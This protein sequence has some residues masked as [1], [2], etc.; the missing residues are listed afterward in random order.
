MAVEIEQGGLKWSAELDYE[1]FAKAGQEMEK[2]LQ[3]VADAFTKTGVNGEKAIEQLESSI[4][5]LEKQQQ[6]LSQALNHSHDPQLTDEYQK[7][8]DEINTKL[9]TQYALLD[10]LKIANEKIAS[11]DT[12]T[13]GDNGETK[14]V[15]KAISAYAE[16]RHLKSE[17]ATQPLSK[18]QFESVL[19]E[20]TEL[21]HRL[22][23]VNQELELSASN[24]AGLE[25][26][27]VGARGV[28]G[29]FE[30]AAGGIALFSDKNEELEKVLKVVIG[31]QAVLNAMEEVGNAVYKNGAL[32]VYLL[33]QF[34]KA[35]AVA[36]TEQAEATG[37]ATGAQEVQNKV[38]EEGIVAQKGLNASMLANPAAIL[39]ASLTA[40]VAI[41]AVVVE[42]LEEA[43]NAQKILAEA[44]QKS[45]DAIAEEQAKLQSL[46][47]VAK[48]DLAT[49]GQRQV[50]LDKL[51]QAYPEYLSNLTEENANTK[52]G[53][54]LIEK[55][56]QLLQKRA[57]AQAAEE[58]Y[59]DKLK[60]VVKAQADIN[61]ALATGGSFWDKLLNTDPVRGRLIDLGKA[62]E[63]SKAALDVVNNA[64]HALAE[65]FQ[66]DAD[67]IKAKIGELENSLKGLT[68]T[69]KTEV[70][71]YI[72]AL[73]KQ[74][75][76]ASTVKPIDE[77]EYDKA[78]KAAFDLAQAQVYAAKKGSYAYIEAQKNLATVQRQW[79]KND[80]QNKANTDYARAANVADEQKYQNTIRELNLEAAKMRADDALIIEKGKN[81]LLLAQGKKYTEEYYNSQA[82]LLKKAAAVEIVEANGNKNKVTEI[83][84]QLT[85][86]LKANEDERLKS[87]L[88]KQKDII[89]AQLANSEE[90][91]Q[92][93]L[94]LKELQL[95]KEL[96]IEESSHNLSD[97][98]RRK[99]EAETAKKI[100][101][102]RK[103]YDTQ[104]AETAIN[105]EISKTNTQ[106]ANAR[107]G[108]IDELNL[109]K[110]LID[111]QASLDITEATKQIKNEQLLAA[112]IAEINSGALVKKKQLDS[113]YLENRLTKSLQNI[114]SIGKQEQLQ[115]EKIL[116]SSRSI[117]SEKLKAQI[118]SD[119]QALSTLYDKIEEV[120]AAYDR[121][122]LRGGE[123]VEKLRVQL[124]DLNTETDKLQQ[125]IINEQSEKLPTELKHTADQINALSSA[126]GNLAN[127]FSGLDSDTSG[128]L[129][130][131]SEIGKTAGDATNAFASFASG[132]IVGGIQGTIQ[133]VGD[134]VGIFSKA[135][136]SA[137]KARA[138]V[139][140]FYDAI[141][142]GEIETDIEQRKRLLTQEQLNKETID[143]QKEQLDLLKQQQQA[144]ASDYQKILDQLYQQQYVSGEHTKSGFLGLSTKV[145]KDY[146]SLYGKT[147]EEL[148]QLFNSGQM[149]DKAKSLFQELEKL[150]SEGDDINSELD[151][152]NEKI[153]ETYTG[154]TSDSLLDG[155]VEGFK[156]GL[157]SASDFADNFQELMTNAVLNSLKY[158]TLE[159]PL[160]DWY[161]TFSQLTQSGDMLT[162]D[163]IDQLQKAYDNIISNAADQFDSLQKITGL[164]L[165][166][167]SSSNSLSGAIKGITE[168]QAELLASQLGGVRVTA[169]QQLNIATQSLNTLNQIA[170]NTSFI[171]NMNS[172][173]RDFQ[174]NG[175]KIK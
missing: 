153:K 11:G 38:T 17:L 31:V 82:Q 20:A 60:E 16:L 131:V 75:P 69:A 42:K 27:K 73:Q 121:A 154:T 119:K 138:E 37:L 107:K 29:A 19:N 113:E 80:P 67:K 108:S 68:G 2:A 92:Q 140:A 70:Q 172:I 98:A 7:G 141:L 136:E 122:V 104:S 39:I 124:R 150:K 22:K 66:S 146:S 72:A 151:D 127:E 63:K 148:E 59:K 166:G 91:S 26:L 40:L 87:S 117:L 171:Y 41:V 56:I 46:L 15:E 169:I 114:D 1:Q 105:I 133:T 174:L 123:D 23:N 6:R 96:E 145:V 28:L 58:V 5:D 100:T 55:Q 109:K 137:E 149:T 129:N 13:Q 74:L 10:N 12:S 132:N 164:S 142:A 135:K 134:I 163:E 89:D 111:E 130:F 18:E 51:R 9:K 162:S 115:Y 81:A 157:R 83:N 152:I 168:N 84:Y 118:D 125:K 90:G 32:N 36:A 24:V 155:I 78:K 34:R 57:L 45:A 88:Q 49:R 126:I 33:Q 116:N 147:Y 93:E 167:S 139:K 143:G 52:E 99:I 14:G 25:A 4:S 64:N 97:E 76:T 128:V 61:E 110:Q 101:D 53:N 71:G 48:D 106:L 35:D 86:E 159:E 95:Q 170:Y 65:A 3:G 156:N 112:K 158:Q 79:F 161:N 120:S 62:S 8:L 30:G 144:N 43:A 102:L 44:E 77:E 165:S 94:L 173:L 21:E 103:E 54:E 47:S 50:A 160:Q 175:V 85:E